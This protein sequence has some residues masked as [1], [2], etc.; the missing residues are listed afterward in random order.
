MSV[1]AGTVVIES[2]RAVVKISRS[3]TQIPNTTAFVPA[4]F[5]PGSVV[6]VDPTSKSPVASAQ[7]STVSRPVSG[8]IDLSAFAQ[9][10]T[11]WRSPYLIEISNKR[12]WEFLGPVSR[13]SAVLRSECEHSVR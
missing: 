12:F 13:N 8:I 3:S 11:F 9:P 7:E 4:F 6:T 5:V 1:V 2:P 10:P